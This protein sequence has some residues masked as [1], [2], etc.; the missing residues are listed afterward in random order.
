[1]GLRDARRV[2][3]GGGG[4][5]LARSSCG[6]RTSPCGWSAPPRRSCSPRAPTWP[7]SSARVAERRAPAASDRRRRRRPALGG[8]PAIDVADTAAADPALADLHVRH[9]GRAARRRAHAGIPAR[10]V[11]A[12]AALARRRAPGELSWCTAASGWSKSARN[13]FVAPWTAGAACLLHDARFDPEER[14]AI[15][16]EHEVAVLCQS[17]TEYRMIAKRASLDAG[18]PPGAAAPRVRG[19]AAQ[20]GGDAGLPRGDAARHPRRLRPDRDGPADRHARRGGACGPARWAGRCPASASRSWTRT[21]S[22]RTRASCAWTRETVPTFFRGYL[23]EQPFADAGGGRATGCA[24][25]ADGFLW[26]EGRLD[27]VILSAG[28][29]DRPIRGRV[30]ADRAPGGRRGRGGGG[31]RRRAG[32][33]RRGRRGPARRGTS[34]TTGLCRSYRST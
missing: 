3:P 1:M 19:R 13:A 9:G 12:G 4:R 25:I 8:R 16:A 22:R 29:P 27:D 2:A 7:S 23:G 30:R 17:P 10:P 32:R 28:L 20:P 31:A 14:L 34:A 6:P 18:R 11:G 21:V 33:G 26:F 24:A 5:C 15:V